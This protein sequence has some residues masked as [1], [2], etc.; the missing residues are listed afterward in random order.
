[1]DIDGMAF[2]GNSPLP[3]L[4]IGPVNTVTSVL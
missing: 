4:E 1:M 3:G 2:D